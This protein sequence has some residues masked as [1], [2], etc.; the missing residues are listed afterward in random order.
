M[1]FITTPDALEA[2]DE[3]NSETTIETKVFYPEDGGHLF[4]PKYTIWGDGS[5]G[6]LVIGSGNLTRGGIRDNHE[7]FAQL[8]LQGEE[9]NSALQEWENWLE[10]HEGDLYAPTN[11]QVKRRAEKNTGWGPST[12][13]SS[14][15]TSSNLDGEA[16]VLVA[17]LPK[18]GDRLKQANFSKGVFVGYFGVSLGAV[19]DRLFKWSPIGG[20]LQRTEKR[21]A[22]RVDS[23]NYRFEL[24]AAD[25]IE[26]PEV[27]KVGRPIGVFLKKRPDAFLYRLVLPTHE[28]RHER[29][30]AFLEER[31]GLGSRYKCRRVTA[32]LDECEEV[33]DVQDLSQHQNVF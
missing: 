10:R 7:A 20:G 2:M 16:E 24:S 1:D 30:E 22:V 23:S 31:E 5:S 13:D 18:N 12:S 28:N 32:N 29:L 15:A 19:E 9:Y 3:I 14:G 25:G 11:D 33:E 17:E 26:Y 21:R 8:S 4:H 6:S 27:E